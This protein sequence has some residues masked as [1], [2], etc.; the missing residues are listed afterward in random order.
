MDVKSIYTSPIK[1]HKSHVVNSTGPK[2][3]S[4]REKYEKKLGITDD[5]E[6]FN[7]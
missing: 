2:I 3:T 6:V 4:N 5:L 1:L 7:K